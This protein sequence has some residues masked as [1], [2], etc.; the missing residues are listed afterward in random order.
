VLMYCPSHEVVNAWYEAVYVHLAT[1]Y[2]VDGVDITHARFPMTSYPRGMFL[3]ACDRCAREAADRGYDMERMK[4][5]ILDARQHIQRMEAERLAQICGH[6]LGPFDALQLLGMRRGVLQWF[7]FR[8]D[9]LADKFGAFRNAV[10]E[11]AGEDFIFGTDTYP[12]S[13]SPFVGHD[14]TRWDTFSDFASPLLSHVDIFPM[15]TMTA[16]AGFL[17]GLCPDLDESQALQMIYRLVGYDGLEMPHTIE[18]FALGAP[19]C[20]F[21]NVPLR[22]LVALDMAK[23]KLYLPADIPSYP[24]IQGGGAPHH[25]PRET[26]EEIMAAA[27]SIGHQ[28]IIFQGVQSLVDVKK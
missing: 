27:E 9:L 7:A 16:W 20:E 6:A 23:A 13:L 15:Q 11:A 24:I 18:E 14:H 10:H 2:D 28:G 1:A 26:I 5:D 21:R 12:A 25:W 19:D 17:Q 4:A 22:D 8:C 3:C